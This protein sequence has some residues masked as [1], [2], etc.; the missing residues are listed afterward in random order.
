MFSIIGRRALE[1]SANDV[2]L[3][4]SSTATDAGAKENGPSDSRKP[5]LISVPG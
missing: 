1:K 3:L 4:L 5:D 2:S